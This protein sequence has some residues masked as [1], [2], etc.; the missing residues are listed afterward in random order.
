[1][2]NRNYLMNKLLK[3]NKLKNILLFISLCFSMFL[4]LLSI[5]FY[6]GI[7]EQKGNLEMLYLDANIFQISTKIINNVG[8]SAL[9]VVKKVRPDL[10]NINENFESIFENFEVDY[11]LDYFTKNSV[12]KV[13]EKEIENFKIKFYKS[14]KYKANLIANNMF[15]DEYDISKN[16]RINIELSATYNYSDTI[17]GNIKEC[18]EEFIFSESLLIED[19]FD[20]FMFLNSPV[21]YINYSYFKE[22]LK[23]TSCDEINRL[24]IKN[25]SRYDLVKNSKNNED[26][27]GYC[28]NLTLFNKDD[29]LKMHQ[30]IEELNNNNSTLEV[31]N[32]SYSLAKSFLDLTNIL[33]FGLIFFAVVA[34][35]CTFLLTFFIT[36]SICLSE[37]KNIAIFNSLGASKS[38]INNIFIKYLL[39]ISIFAIFIAL[40]IFYL[41]SMYLNEFIYNSFLIKDILPNNL[42]SFSNE[43]LVINLSLILFVIFLVTSITRLSINKFNNEEIYEELKEE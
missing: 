27:G 41:S 35:I 3:T 40:L 20:E 6:F 8:S 34:L 31:K 30:I 12:I 1:M 7:N 24:F 4:S 32:D 26:L 21:I 29:I 15:L 22:V 5:S 9:S 19:S 2:R 13:K 42:E 18:N 37:R 23:A 14:E 16:E 33:K 28:Y 17:N 43:I 11:N 39:Y 10:E 36:C 25:I 38:N